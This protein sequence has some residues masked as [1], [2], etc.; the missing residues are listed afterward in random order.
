MEVFTS[1]EGSKQLRVQLFMDGRVICEGRYVV[2]SDF[3]R[4]APAGTIA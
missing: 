3:S 1:F 2:M 4:R